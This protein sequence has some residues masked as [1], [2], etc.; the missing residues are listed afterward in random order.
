[1]WGSVTCVRHT[2]LNV[3]VQLGLTREPAVE[4]W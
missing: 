2:A 4:T 3:P 1:L